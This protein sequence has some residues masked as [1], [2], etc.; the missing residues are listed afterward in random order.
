MIKLYNEDCL[1]ALD[2]IIDDSVDLVFTDPPYNL[3][4]FAKKRGYHVNS[5]RENSFV[6][7]DWDNV[8]YDDWVMLMNK[9]FEK[10]SKVSKIGSSLVMFISS[11]RI[12][13]IIN[14][15][16]KYKYYYKTTGV[17]HKTNPM[18]RN[19]NLHFVNSNEFWLYFI[20]RKR[21]GTFNNNNKLVL[22]YIE[23]SVTPLSE[24]TI[25]R[26]PTQKP[27]QLIEPLI[28]ILSNPTDLVIDPFMG[29]GTTGVAC[30]KLNRNFIGI[31]TNKEYF[32]LANNR[33]SEV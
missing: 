28:E 32:N 5:M 1:T 8:S 3:G 18:P 26:H 11:L 19:M 30:K 10:L 22:D 33:I 4:N 9:L 15:A 6:T 13:T 12:E 29:S 14:I 7:S 17:W 27:L 23:T 24:K 16:E 31:E 2:K 25:G 21:T 20:Y